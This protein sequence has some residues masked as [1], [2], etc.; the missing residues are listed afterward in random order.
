MNN[1]PK[2]LRN[3]LEEISC[4]GHIDIELK[5]ESKVDNT[6]NICFY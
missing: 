4:I 6:K 5:L 1:I 3:K 2:S